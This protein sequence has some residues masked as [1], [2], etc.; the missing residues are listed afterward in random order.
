M[1][2]EVDSG[3]HA[4]VPGVDLFPV[5]AVKIQVSYIQIINDFRQ[6]QLLQFNLFIWFM[7]LLNA[8]IYKSYNNMFIG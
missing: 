1:M 2:M 3:N 8:Y 6:N 5:S 7:G 4:S